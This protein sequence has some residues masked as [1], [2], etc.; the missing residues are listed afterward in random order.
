MCFAPLI[1]IGY[2]FT[3]HPNDAHVTSVS[4]PLV[5]IQTCERG[6]GLDAKLTRSGM[7]AL[8]LQYGVVA[9][10]SGSWSWV[11]TPKVGGAVLP[12]H[13]SELTSTVNFSLGFQSAIGYDSSRFALEYWH[14]SNAGLG[15][16]N[17]GLDLVAVLGG[18]VF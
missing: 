1:L 4:N 11:L 18:W 7:S 8:S 6:L 9:V 2:L 12:S 17:A 14:Q 16:T 13:V 3:M 15:T 10:D 5:E